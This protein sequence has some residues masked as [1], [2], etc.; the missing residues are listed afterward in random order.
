MALDETSIKNSFKEKLEALVFD[1]SSPDGNVK[2]QYAQA[3]AEWI[4]ETIQSATVTIPSGA[5]ITTGSAATQTQ[6]VPAVV[7]NAIS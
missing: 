6:S 1:H 7:D 2:E 3:M 4:I 5:I